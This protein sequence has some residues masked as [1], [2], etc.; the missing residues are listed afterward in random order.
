M[1]IKR[2]LTAALALLA[3]AAGA[4]AQQINQ[5]IPEPK[6]GQY[7]VGDDYFLANY[8]QLID[9]WTSLAKA[10]D[11]ISL[12]DIGTT[13]EG[14]TMKIAIITSAEN[15]KHLDRYKE[16]SRKLASAEG[17]N[18][19]QAH[20]FAAE[21]K[22][23]VWIGAGVHATETVNAQA[24]FSFAYEMTAKNDPETLRILNDDILIL[25]P[26]NPDGMELVSN[27]YMREADPAK[28][29]M[30]IP[31]LYQKYVGHDNNRDSYTA[32]QPETEAVDHEMYI[33]WI[34]QIMY[35]QH[36]SGPAGAVLF[37]SPFR[38]PFN[39]NTDPLAIIGIDLVGA[40]VHDRFLSENKPGAVL[41]SG[42]PYS[43]WTNGTERSTVHFHNQIGVLTEIIGTPA[44]MSIPLVTSKLLPNGD[45]PLPI[46]PQQV[47]HQRQSIE[48][49]STADRAI[50]DLASK[51]HEDF[52]FNIYRMGKNS[53]ERGSKDY[54][55]LTPKRITELEDNVAKD[56]PEL[57]QR[58][59]QAGGDTGAGP[60]RQASIP[61]KYY[62]QLH[63]PETRDPR[64]YIIPSDQ[65]DFPTA[66][67]F[68]N[69]L[70]K[71]GIEVD[72]AT[73][74]F[75]VAGKA[76]PAGSY[77][78]Q[79]AQ[80]FRPHLR[81]MFEPQDYPNDL[82]YPGGPPKPPYDVAGYTLALQM[83]VQFDRIL[84]AF[85]APTERLHGILAPPPGK[86]AELKRPTGYLLSHQFNDA[87]TGTTRLLAAG[88]DVYW[89]QNAFTANKKT[90]PI[91]TIYI[92]AKKTTQAQVEKLAAD[93]GLNFDAIA[94]K[95][96]GDALKIRPVRIGLWDRY[97][98]SMD[99]GQI[100]WLLEK[101]FPIPFN[102]IY[103][104]ELNAGDLRSK[105]DVLIFPN[106]AIPDPESRR[107]R[108]GA[109]SSGGRNFAEP[110]DIPDEFKNRIGNVTLDKTGPLLKQF[111][112]DGGTLVTIG[113]ST[114][115]G[116]YLGLPIA[117]GLVEGEG[118]AQKRL[119]PEKFFI[120][121]SIL[122]AKVDNTRPVSYG[123]PETLNVY[124]Q[125]NPSFVLLPGAK[126]K[127]VDTL[128]WFDSSETLRSGWALGQEY[129]DKKSAVVEAK[130]GKGQVLLFGPEIT[131]RAQPHGTFKLL[132]NGIYSAN[133][134]PVKLP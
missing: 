88:E 133:A 113:S 105:Y 69:S 93:L 72:R 36:Q 64:G 44:P 14:R 37:M 85:T 38:D 52:L 8:T 63:S 81:D 124:Y 65:P 89:L 9:Y 33:D 26:A 91:G 121:G 1:Q 49:L 77:V 70:L 125:N 39:Y 80:A 18:D 59:E 107:G 131:F 112:E 123:L 116:Y 2:Y 67:K 54:W 97:G 120:P 129:L 104:P 118:D 122:E 10:S 58:G 30:A 98:G 111:V 82:Q 60:Q 128:A 126:E 5:G 27:W 119:P 21:G 71:T 46:G 19:D 31:R 66:T 84:D 23:V 12:V 75:T 6:F 114:G 22:A 50:L 101:A 15:Q 20:A 78:V 109:G 117:N 108:G 32:N 4:R 127:N 83:G 56:H 87:F 47:W 53:I 94:V 13:A 74:S 103:A 42:A 7:T 68:V 62:E 48:Y 76:Y 16:I 132:F 11:R 134:E 110:A 43:T 100:R 86:V 61:V 79:A 106:G 90:Y 29:N 35:T 25:A 3:L 34:P 57:L 92:P 45:Q 96:H 24:L 51:Y 41:R 55:T 73:T 115:F 17:L 130:V 102:V 95:P 99:S 40:A 28:R